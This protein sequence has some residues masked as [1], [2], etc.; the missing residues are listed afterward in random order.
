MREAWEWL[1]CF[2]HSDQAKV[3]P[4][5][6][7]LTYSPV[8]F[9]CTCCM[10]MK[11][12]TNSSY[13]P[14]GSFGHPFLDI[15]TL[16]V[17]TSTDWFPLSWLHLCLLL[18][19]SPTQIALPKEKEGDRLTVT[20]FTKEMLWESSVED[21]QLSSFGATLSPHYLLL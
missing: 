21:H 7:L 4:S 11:I 10:V 15:T 3:E 13:F 2:C 19:Y 5:V 8:G 18:L 6:V 9:T 1:P 16:T 17:V 14:Q 12:F 20:P